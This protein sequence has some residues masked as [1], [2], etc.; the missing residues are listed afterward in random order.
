M[1]QRSRYVLAF[2]VLAITLVLG[3]AP[4]ATPPATTA[5]TQPPAPTVAAPTTVPPTAVPPTAPAAAT[6]KIRVAT[7]QDP[8]QEKL[9]Q[10]V[11][12]AFK[13]AHPNI[14]VEYITAPPGEY[15][16]KL[17]V[18]LAGGDPAD[19]YLSGIG[20]PWTA[21]GI[22]ANTYADLTER[23]N[24]DLKGKLLETAVTTWT[25]D[26]KVYGIPINVEALGNICY[27][28]KLFDAAGVKY[29]TNDWTGE[30]Y[31]AA[32]KQLVKRDAAGKVTVWGGLP[33]PDFFYISVP[34]ILTSNGG[35]AFSPDGKQW[36]AGIEPNLSKNVAAL[37]PYVA[38]GAVDKS[39]P[40]PAETRE[41][42]FGEGMFERGELAMRHCGFY[43][44]PIYNK[45]AGLDYGVVIN[46]SWKV[47]PYVGISPL[48]LVMSAQSKNPEAAWEFI[49]FM[50]SPEMQSAQFQAIGSLPTNLD[51]LNSPELVSNPVF[52]HIDL[53][54]WIAA[55]M[56]RGEALPGPHD[57]SVAPFAIS[58]VWEK[59][60]D[61]A[62]SGEISVKDALTRMQPEMEKLFTP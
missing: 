33:W 4:A 14:D 24:A 13:A 46:D 11:V 45:V 20:F 35:A 58:A 5:A 53:K 56:A 44:L 59:Y 10:D 31:R 30:D 8:A 40:T 16:D 19:V 42:G 26:G 22:K 17:N 61:K 37:E 18:M 23:Y 36:V 41:Q 28:K 29:P 25:V 60:M 38:M 7:W 15:P 39:V 27:N 47:K 62:W 1:L 51:V 34:G 54:A 43:H 9:Y 3:C 57:T 55:T 12:T 6:T 50:T 21:D 48:G 49:K 32:A 52:A 2:V